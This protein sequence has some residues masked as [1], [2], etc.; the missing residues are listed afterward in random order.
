MN[1]MII[2][3]NTLPASPTGPAYIAGAALRAGHCVEI[4]ETLFAQDVPAELSAHIE[5]FRPEVIGIS[6]RLV[7]AY[8]IDETAPYNTRHIDLRLGVRQM[9]DTIRQAADVPIILGGP[10]FNYYARDWLEY[11]DLD[12]GIR[13]EADFPFPLYLDLLAQGGDLTAVPGCIF[14]QGG[15]FRIW[16]IVNDWRA[17]RKPRER[18]GNAGYDGSL[19]D[20][21]GGLDNGRHL[22]VD[23]APRSSRRCAAGG[24]APR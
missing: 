20:S 10:G 19:H 3:S 15:R 12:Y 16:S 13:G 4:F 8:I 24:P 2:S 23:A 21:L 1:V 11:L 18:S 6:I 17:R 14:R 7:H 9:V 5:R 22:L